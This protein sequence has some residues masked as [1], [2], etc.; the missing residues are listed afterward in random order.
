MS[1]RVS[2]LPVTVGPL[3]L[4]LVAIV[5]SS[6]ESHAASAL[7]V[8]E[9]AL[10]SALKMRPAQ[11]GVTGDGWFWGWSSSP[12]DVACVSPAGVVARG[13]RVSPALAVD[14]DRTFGVAALTEAG[15]GLQIFSWT[16]EMLRQ[17]SLPD[18]MFRLAWIDART[19]AVTPRRI[20]YRVLLIDITD[21]RVKAQIGPVPPVVSK[22]R[23]AVLLRS[24]FVRFSRGKKTLVTLDGFGGELSFFSIATQARTS[25]QLPNPN[26]E[27]MSRW[28]QDYDL[29]AV[30]SGM[31]ATSGALCYTSLSLDSDGRA[32][33]GVQCSDERLLLARVDSYSGVEEHRLPSTGC[34]TVWGA[35]W[36]EYWVQ[37]SDPMQGPGGCHAT[38]KL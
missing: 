2:K 18:E 7:K 8:S 25:W 9:K 20:G 15:T 28:L 22:S 6:R 36:G 29:Q 16:G 30:A 4:L 21:G 19:V 26:G 31:P 10:A 37:H 23:G 14:V 24:T 35:A 3:L 1:R 17:F 32:W 5:P 38:R 27:A 34:C 11:T 12:G 33:V 13:P